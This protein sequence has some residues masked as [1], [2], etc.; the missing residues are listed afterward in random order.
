M[1]I[2]FPILNMLHRKFIVDNADR[3]KQNCVGRGV[4]CDVDR[5]VEL[6]TARK[7]KLLWRRN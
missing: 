4:K 1:S 2:A 5:L 6:E 3:V 7:A